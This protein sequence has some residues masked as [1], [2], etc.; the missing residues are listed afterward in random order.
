MNDDLTNN[1]DRCNNPIINEVLRAILINEILYQ[2]FI[3]TILKYWQGIEDKV[4]SNETVL[5]K[6]EMAHITEALK[7]GE[8]M[9]GYGG[10]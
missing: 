8:K 3:A 4:G 9:T 5:S 1:T 10:H 2:E 6:T 7:L